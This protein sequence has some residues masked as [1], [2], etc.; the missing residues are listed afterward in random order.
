MSSAVFANENKIEIS[1]YE[2]TTYFRQ[3]FACTTD[4]VMDWDTS[5][6]F[7]VSCSTDFATLLID[8]FVIF[9]ISSWSLLN[10][11]KYYVKINNLK[12][13]LYWITHT[14]EILI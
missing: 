8:P 1:P 11:A 6:I 2:N 14:I 12:K 10:G 13:N 7:L 3:F 5:E 4:F 9:K